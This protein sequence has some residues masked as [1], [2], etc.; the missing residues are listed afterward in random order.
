MRRRSPGPG[1]L[2]LLA[3]LLWQA[4]AK[5]QQVAAPGT[6]AGTQGTLT[7]TAT[8]AASVGLLIGPDGEQRLFIANAADRADNVSRLQPVAMV[9]PKP[10]AG[11]KVPLRA[12]KLPPAKA[13]KSH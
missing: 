3:V 13:L 6:H 4:R 11:D 5:A 7:V 8:I 9:K 1:F 10:T 2:L 12:K